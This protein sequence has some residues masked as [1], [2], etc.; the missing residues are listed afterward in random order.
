MMVKPQNWFMV[1]VPFA[2]YLLAGKSKVRMV[3]TVALG[4]TF[5]FVLLL[6]GGYLDELNRYRNNFLS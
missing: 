6:F 1:M 5:V 2:M 4:F 3:L